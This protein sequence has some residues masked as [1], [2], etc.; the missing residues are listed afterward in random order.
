VAANSTVEIIKKLKNQKSNERL[1]EATAD[2]PSETRVAS[3]QVS[4]NSN[5]KQKFHR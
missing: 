4:N 5:Q 2:K 3:Q 1:P